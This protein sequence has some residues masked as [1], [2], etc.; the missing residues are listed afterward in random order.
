MAITPRTRFLYGS[1]L[2]Q[3]RIARLAAVILAVLVEASTGVIVKTDVMRLAPEAK[4]VFLTA[5]G[6]S[7][8]LSIPPL[9]VLWFL[10]RRE[11]ESVWLYV[12]MFLWGALIATALSSPLKNL[13]FPQ[14][15]PL[16]L[17]RPDLGDLLGDDIRRT[18]T[19]LLSTPL[20]EEICKGAGVLLAFFL[21]KAE[22][23]SVRDGFIYGALVG[24]GF[25][26]M[27]SSFFVADAY[28][29]TGVAPWWQYLAMHHS[30]FGFGGHVLYTGLFGMGLGLA[31]QTI[32]PWLHIV[33]PITCWLGGLTAHLIGNLMA[34][35]TILLAFVAT[36]RGLLTATPTLGASPSD[37]AF[38]VL[39]VSGSYISIF[40]AFPFLVVA[41]LMLWQSGV[42]E[43][44]VIRDELED[45]REPVI[46]GEEY[47]GIL[48]DRAFRTRKVAARDAATARAIVRAQ[49]ELAIRKWR[50]RHM[51][52]PLESDPLVVSWRE[53][54]A[55]LRQGPLEAESVVPA[56]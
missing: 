47:D 51:G 45:E 2:S 1:P 28:A 31:R 26:L 44:K 41:V 8:L 53:E 9:V 15:N 56:S 55:R 39:L 23:D 5:L 19:A 21:L 34:L 22:F 25:N 50:L 30:L 37:P 11:R 3:P 42:W 36:G 16:F 52:H 20:I 7:A 46:S 14:G 35:L 12:V 40:W 54:L 33:A 29:S 38:W 32:R 18:L 13:L 4:A 17:L 48:R 10:D 43:R 27:E 24:V 49:N 6:W